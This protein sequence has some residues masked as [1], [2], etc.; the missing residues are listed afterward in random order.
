MVIEIK[1][2]EYVLAND[3]ESDFLKWRSGE[4]DLGDKLLIYD[5]CPMYFDCLIGTGFEIAFKVKNKKGEC[6]YQEANHET[7]RLEDYDSKEQ[8]EKEFIK[9]YKICSEC[10]NREIKNKTDEEY[11]TYLKLKEKYENQG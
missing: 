10:W 4:N 7:I 3:K 6:K 9:E 8:F 1:L 5:Y 11:E 2:W